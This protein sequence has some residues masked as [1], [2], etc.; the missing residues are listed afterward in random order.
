MRIWIC[1]YFLL[2]HLLSFGQPSNLTPKLWKPLAGTQ[3]E[4]GTNQQ[5]SLFVL[6]QSA[7]EKM[8]VDAPNR[9]YEKLTAKKTVIAFP[10]SIGTYQSFQIEET[11]N[12]HPE[13]AKLYPQIKAYVGKAI[14]EPSTTIRFD[15]SQKGFSGMIHSTKKG[16]IFID[17]LT[18]DRK[19]HYSVYT[20][21]ELLSAAFDCKV[22]QLQNK[23]NTERSFNRN[24]A[25]DCQL[26][27]FRLALACTGEYAAYH[28]GTTADALAAMNSTLTI[29]NG[30]YEQEV[31]VTFQLIPNTTDLI[32]LNPATDPY[33]NN[34]L[35]DMLGEN[36]M[37]CDNR[38]GTDNYDIGHVFGT[39][40][41]GVAFLGVVCDG[42]FK[43]G[44][45]TGFIRP[46]GPLFAI[47]LVSHEIGHQ[48][49]A[50]HTFSGD[51]AAC[52]GSNRN[53]ETAVEPGSGSTIM[54]YAGICAPQN[55]Q[56]NSD[57][58]FHAIS[59]EQMHA[60]FDRTDCANLPL[61][62]N[63]TT[64]IITTSDAAYIIPPS[65]PFM[66]DM[67]AEERND[68]FTYTWEQMDNG[69][70]PQPPRSTSRLGPLFRSLPPSNS[71]T[72]YFPNLV[73]L[74]QNN[75]PVWE[76]LPSVGRLMN[77]RG[78][79][80][81]NQLN[82]G[83]SN[84][85]NVTI[86]VVNIAPFRVLSPNTSLIWE[87]GTE[88]N[89]TW[90][91]GNTNEN[92]INTT[93]VDIFLSL[94][95]GLT[96]PIEVAH[97]LPNTGEGIIVVPNF[98]STRCRIMVK[99]ANNIFFDISDRDLEITKPANDFEITVTANQK[100]C[101]PAV[102][103]YDIQLSETGTFSENIQ[104][105]T[106][107]L[108]NG[109]TAIFSNDRPT[110]PN[111]VEL[112]IQNTNQLSGNYTF[113]LIASG[114]TGEKSRTLKL[115][116]APTIPKSIL[117]RNPPN[118]SRN[119]PTAPTFIWEQAKTAESYQLEIAEALTFENPIFSQNKIVDTF[120]TL[121]QKLANDTQYFWRV[122]G[123]N[124]CGEG[125]FGA[126]NTFETVNE[127]CTTFKPTDLPLEISPIFRATV[128]SEIRILEVGEILSIQLSN[129]EISHSF[130]SDL[131]IDLESPTGTKIRLID[132]ICGAEQDL[133]LNFNSEAATMYSAIP[134][135]PTNNATIQ[136]LES[137]SALIGTEMQGTW[138]LI[139][140]DGELLDGGMLEQWALDICYKVEKPFR[141]TTNKT[142]VNCAGGNDGSASIL[143]TGGSGNYQYLWSNGATNASL[144]NLQTGIYGVTISDG[145]QT[146][147]T[148]ITIDEP[149]ALTLDFIKDKSGCVGEN[150]GAI[151]TNVFGG[152]GA[153]QYQWSN[154]A[155]SNNL[156]QLE[157]DIYTVTVTDEMDCQIIDSVTLNAFPLVELA[158][159]S[160]ANPRCPADSIGSATIISSD[161][162]GTIHYE[163]SNGLIGSI[164][165]S[166]PVGNYL[167]KATDLN[168]CQGELMVTIDREFDEVPPVLGL[169]STTIYLA[170]NGV[171]ELSISAIDAGS[172]DDCGSVDLSLTQ[173][174]FDCQNIGIQRVG[175]TGRDASG[176]ET[177]EEIN[178]I[179]LDTFSPVFECLDFIQIIGCQDVTA[180]TYPKAIDNCGTVS[181][182]LLTVGEDG[183]ESDTTILSFR[184]VDG[185]GN[186]A[187]C[188]VPIFRE[189]ELTV[190]SD[191][192]S[193]TCSGE[194]DGEAT[195]LLSGGQ[196][197]YTYLWNDPQSQTTFTATNLASGDYE[198]TIM[199]NTGCL[200]IEK[201]SIGNPSPI[202]IIDSVITADINGMANG[203]IQITA[204][205]G[206][207]MLQAVW[208]KG[209]TLI[210]GG[211]EVDSLIAGTYQLRLNDENGCQLTTTFLVD[212]LTSTPHFPVVETINIYPNPTRGFFT[213]DLTFSTPQ[214][215]SLTLL[216][217]LGEIV[218]PSVDLSGKGG[219]YTFD[220]ANFDNGI[221]LLK[222]AAEGGILTKPIVLMK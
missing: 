221:Y 32:F 6:D 117:L 61:N 170:E 83:C 23:L 204:S 199:D 119:I 182:Q 57:P 213:V 191:A 51:E 132:K 133:S 187:F 30:V 206:T 40:L 219:L 196:A 11:N 127:T 198:V 192:I 200:F 114:S 165:D 102:A 197:P 190:L 72:R 123:E 137:L 218:V 77:F 3:K 128:S 5:D 155:T 47:D 110:V 188:Y 164:Q 9:Q 167:L 90:E 99:A 171:G 134:C 207:G 36:Q 15:I 7:L 96:Y 113:N 52:A 210:G 184:A 202:T 125:L 97:N 14:D 129:V 100:V 21:K 150:N 18:T 112:S 98:A 185:N 84:E 209:D 43:A 189:I 104:L 116:V 44:G 31:A 53:N 41:G 58:Y 177:T 126:V 25:G 28:G 75:T 154:G 158:I 64:P 144:E 17:N 65:T 94:D 215:F 71:S 153:Y 162:T 212:M 168:G 87:A 48:L 4:K 35:G 62:F 93:A 143:P 208:F 13:L 161:I 195:L 92:P 103:I 118:N 66:L 46:E 205:G 10:L 214:N 174:L 141:F 69:I 73:D 54:A 156:N 1:L 160:Q 203:S 68:P 79:V 108:P 217:L 109:V 159:E 76:V 95:G 91:V 27:T 139:V 20:K 176:N 220:V 136:P 157:T 78:T 86:E 163:W 146:L 194:N 180:E 56:D 107:N 140:Q 131:V 12:L 186:E 60:T 181:A 45:A 34:D 55:V 124:A 8:V 152:T 173:H 16:L 120:Y 169:N 106:S 88:K 178:I 122:K 121:T 135:P 81:D 111:S 145:A 59:L 183:F 50:T 63:N 166:L 222:I 39:D 24:N 193:P 70:A 179:V 216:N 201:I 19:D 85:V 2:L 82:G 147:D 105:T 42:A 101:I 49:G 211:F 130:I 148:T 22:H 33:T 37:V 29:I 67:S 115:N 74:T 26:R 175:V 142:G 172:F 89:I 149:L 151:I 38:I 138:T 80:R